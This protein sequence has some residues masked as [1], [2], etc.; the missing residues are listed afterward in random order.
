MC[1]ADDPVGAWLIA[2]TDP[3][4]IGGSGYFRQVS[5]DELCDWFWYA[6]TAA[7]GTRSGDTGDELRG[8]SGA[9]ASTRSRD[10]SDQ[11]CFFGYRNGP[12]S[13][14]KSLARLSGGRSG[15]KD[16]T[17]VAENRHAVRWYDVMSFG[18]PASGI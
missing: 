18:Q 6:C 9:A 1:A 17:G 15:T 13:R 3:H 8:V 12:D 4:R 5:R 10:P 2:A 14:L 11:R 16:H 7:A